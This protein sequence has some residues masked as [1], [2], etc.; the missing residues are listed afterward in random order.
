MATKRTHSSPAAGDDHERWLKGAVR[1]KLS[2]MSNAKWRKV[3]TAIATSSIE[4]RRCEFKCIDSE[5]VSVMPGAPQVRD[6]MERRFA[7]SGWQPFEY[8][9]IEWIRFPRQFKPRQGIGFVVTQ[10]VGELQKAIADA[11]ERHA[12]QMTCAVE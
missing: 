7:D 9:W 12:P 6:L 11:V 10:D 2:C 8:K 3:L 1:F 5:Y 4:I